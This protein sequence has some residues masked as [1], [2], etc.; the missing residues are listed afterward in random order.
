MGIGR[1]LIRRA[2]PR[3]IRH[4]MHPV[5]T[6]KNKATPRPIRQISRGIYTVT[7]PLGA[8]ESA[9]I[10][11]SGRHGKK[12]ARTRQAPRSV[13]A[14][15]IGV[16][17]AEAR[18]VHDDLSKQLAVQRERF[19][20]VQ[21]PVLLPPPPPVDP[22]ALIEQEWSKRRSEVPF[23]R[24]S[25]RKR[26]KAEISAAAHS[27]AAAES[28]RTHAAHDRRQVEADAWWTALNQGDPGV[29]SS[30]L[31]AA[32]ADNP[33]PVIV[34]QAGEAQALLCLIL[35]WPDVLPAK[36]A[37]VTP[38]GRVSSKMWTKTELNDVYVTLCGGHL[39]ATFR[40]AWATAPSLSEIRI[41]GV[42]KRPKQSIEVLFDVEA[43][44]CDSNWD[45]D[46]KGSSILSRSDG[47]K[48]TGQAREVQAWLREDLPKDLAGLVE[49]L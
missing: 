23:W 27:Q 15:G 37:H 1:K 24:S 26:L 4:A 38:T 34:L 36:K 8:A 46:T 21:K 12:P 30:A 40:E 2:T 13:D 31:K 25:D 17:A 18:S 32:F 45:D 48:R 42:R 39:L 3:P 14:G 10:F 5:R 35:P 33:A 47:L 9:V 43:Y 7:N 19:A 29:V 49:Q 44:R 16:R 6:V 22:E 20:P 28:T 11:G 41:F